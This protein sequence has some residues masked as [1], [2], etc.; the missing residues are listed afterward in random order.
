MDMTLAQANLNP[1]ITT[2]GRSND[3]VN[4]YNKQALDVHQYSKITYHDVYPGIDWAI[5]TSNGEVKYDFIVKPGADPSLIKLEFTHQEELGMD[6]SGGFTLKNRMGSISEKKPVSFQDGKEIETAFMLKD[7]FISFALEEY[8]SSSTLVIDPAMVWS[9]YYGGS[10]YEGY[11]PNMGSAIDASGNVYIA[12]TTSSSSGIGSGGYQNTFGG[13]NAPLSLY[14][15]DGYLVKFNS[16]GVRQWATYY[17]GTEVDYG[18]SC[19]VDASGNVYLAGMTGSTVNIASGGYQN[20][21]GGG[22]VPA[23]QGGGDAYLV[24]FNSSG[25]RQWATYYGGTGYEYGYTCA[26]DA[27]GNVYLGGSTSSSAGISSAGFQ[28]TYTGGADAFLVQFNSSGVRQWAT[29]YGDAGSESGNAITT[30]ASGNVY[31]AGSSN[32][33]INIASGGFQNTTG[34]GG[35]AFLVKFT[36]AGVRVWGTYYG[37]ATTDFGQ[38]CAM[39]ASGNVF[40]SGSTTSSANIASGGFQNTFA[41]SGGS[42]DAFLVKFNSS[43]LRQWATY[44]GGA[45]DD[46]GYSCVADVLG[47]VYLAGT[48][49]STS[50]IAYL[51]FQST[52]MGVG[53]GPFGQGG[54]AFLACF[55][56]SS[57]ARSWG[58]YFGGAD[59]ENGLGCLADP[60]GGV[61]LTGYTAST[62]NIATSG[63]QQTTLGGVTD[64]FLCK[65]CTNVAGQP[66]AISGNTMVCMLSSQAYSAT[67]VPGAN[68]YIWTFPGTSWTGTST[69]SII[70]ATAGAGGVL[71]VAA[72]NT[73]GAGLTQTVYI[74]SNSL[75]VI[76][77]GSG[78]I[79]A[80][81]SF[82]ITPGSGVATYTISGGSAIVSPTAN[83]S[84]SITGA[85]AVGC[86]TSAVANVTVN[87]IPSISVNSG[88][89]CAGQSFTLAPGGAATYTYS[90]GPAI[91][92]PITTTNYSVTGT[93]LA[94][95]TSTAAAVAS[96]T[97][98]AI[99][100]IFVNS[101]F[102]CAGQS[103]IMMP[104]GAS[105]YAYYTSLTSS[106]QI[107][108]SVAL[109]P[110]I[111]TTY[112]VTGTS[113][114]GCTSPAVISVVAVSIA[115]TLSIGAV[116]AIICPGEVLTL[117]VFG[118]ANSYTWTS[119]PSSNLYVVNPVT[120]TVYS[121]SG[122]ANGCITMATFTLTVNACTG[123]SENYIQAPAF[124]I[125]PNPG[126]GLFTVTSATAGQAML[127]VYNVLGEKILDLDSLGSNATEHFEQQ[128]DLSAL[129]NGM[130]LLVMRQAART[131]SVLRIIKE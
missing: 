122:S 29:Y 82:T 55:S 129:S 102:I 33:T 48:T 13:Y 106:S 94:G 1:L 5:Y 38:C 124:T 103:F 34:G 43:G 80:G 40:L 54:D 61:Y 17:G 112:S 74:N 110:T 69:T 50:N 22:S 25:A 107:S 31:L 2:E 97:V 119:G 47:N 117:A 84:Y 83:T 58:T 28:N 16:S 8:S 131:I 99:P 12:G 81:Q 46:N 41:G 116:K 90:G 114:L 77:A 96:I 60:L 24:K 52:Y 111:N 104:S 64:A 113:S 56:N 98:N 75:P 89:V 45:S 109:S 19:A 44:Y 4:Y 95:C 18:W 23:Y 105:T 88:S 76:S 101:G 78:S 42:S 93:S 7:N 126:N 91:V 73:C 120:T 128:V 125:Y 20:T 30:D 3:Y 49:T 35:D 53:T 118:N 66:S 39:D 21:Y 51:G 68:G 14:G 108:G 79:C 121:V 85:S 115:P 71:A 15:G 36:N 63:A 100:I 62:V 6:K 32:S 9:T 27:S 59:T 86:T 127:S 65:F 92:S 130:Y 57:G 67:A 37:G 26:T 72:T 11:L 10:D 87:A 70:S 123:I